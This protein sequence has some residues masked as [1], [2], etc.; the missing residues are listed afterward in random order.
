MSEA[1]RDD[2]PTMEEILASIRKIISE[3]DPEEKAQAP[4]AGGSRD[5]EEREPMEL[6]QL[7]SEDGSV[8]DLRSEPRASLVTFDEETDDEPTDGLDDEDSG[9]A[10]VELMVQEGSR[11]HVDLVDEEGGVELGTRER[12]ATTAD[13]DTEMNASPESEASSEIEQERRASP[14][15]RSRP[16]GLVSPE[17]AVAAAA[18]M[19]RLKDSLASGAPVGG[20]GK[21]LEALVREAMAPHLKAWLDENLPDLVERVVREEVERLARRAEDS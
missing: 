17:V 19:S 2:E 15:P 14:A 21:T 4:D 18:A 9:A 10:N 1:R 20:G 13:V 7:V 8:V 5:D 6:T 11:A 16:D 12:E 3:D